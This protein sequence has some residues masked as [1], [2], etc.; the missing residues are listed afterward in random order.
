MW[1]VRMRASERGVHISGAEGLFER[2]EIEKALHEYA[3]RAASHPRGRPDSI[4]ITIERLDE[5]PREIMAL[6]LMTLECRSPEE[7]QKHASGLLRSLGVSV[8]AIRNTYRMLN[9]R[10]AMRGAALVDS[11]SGRRLE[12][13]RKRG[14][15]ASRL[16]VERKAMASMGRRLGRLGL[17]TDTVKEA[18]ALASKVASADGVLAELCMSDDPHYTT[19]YLASRR[20]GYIRLPNI[21]KKGSGNGGRVFFIKSGANVTRIIRYLEERPVIITRLSPMRGVVRIE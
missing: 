12:P 1:S 9:S 8:N 19:G 5:R 10:S 2:S 21:K 16:G 20:L 7:T 15:R 6:P 18:L 11:L 17:N 4:T 13:D 14:V 3:R